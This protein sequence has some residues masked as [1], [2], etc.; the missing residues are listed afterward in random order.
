MKIDLN[1]QITAIELQ[2]LSQRGHVANLQRLLMKKERE[3]FHIEQAESVISKLEAVLSTLK[4]L[5]A[6]EEIIRA[7]LA[8]KV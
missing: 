3:P 5:K 7:A 2:I 6:N 1:A 4:W 8:K